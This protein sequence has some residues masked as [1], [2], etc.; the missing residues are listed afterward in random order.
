MKHARAVEAQGLTLIPMGATDNPRPLTVL[1][2]HWSR[3]S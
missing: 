2:A 3:F 1:L